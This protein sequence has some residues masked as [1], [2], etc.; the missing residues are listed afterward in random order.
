[1]FPKPFYGQKI[2]E[3]FFSVGTEIQ[4]SLYAD[5]LILLIHYDS[6]DICLYVELELLHDVALR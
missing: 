3:N 2:K 6:N 1:M 5:Y 4:V